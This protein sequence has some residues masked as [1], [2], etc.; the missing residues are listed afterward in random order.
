M[1]KVEL[2]ERRARV[3]ELEQQ[4]RGRGRGGGTDGGPRRAP[5]VDRLHALETEAAG[6]R[7]PFPAP[8]VAQPFQAMSNV[9]GRPLIHTQQLQRTPSPPLPQVSELTMSTEYQLRLKD[10]HAAVGAARS[11]TDPR[12]PAGPGRGTARGPVGATD[13]VLPTPGQQLNARRP[14]DSGRAEVRLLGV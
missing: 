5:P 6:S 14:K 11:R 12:A 7:L 1:S 4:A 3:A 13:R 10:L 2:D 8:S 9:C